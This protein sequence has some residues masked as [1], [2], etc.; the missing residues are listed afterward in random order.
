MATTHVDSDKAA[1]AI[2][3][4]VT[5]AFSN[6]SAVSVKEAVDTAQ[7]VIG[8]LGAA[9]QLT[10]MITL[11]AGI[12]VLAGTVASTEAQRL[13]DSVI[14]KVLGATRVSI[15]IAWFLEYAL[16]GVLTGVAA[17]I[18]GSLASWALINGLLAADF[19]MDFWL[20]LGTTL[21]GAMA[22]ALLGLAGAVRTLGF[23]PAPLLRQV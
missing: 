5:D 23:K 18:I 7:R 10:A 3:R 15:S 4:R 17:A 21:A 14:L 22:T 6:V 1:D 12:A 11:V 2:E 19:E 13:A 20:V 8:L 9:V 16:L